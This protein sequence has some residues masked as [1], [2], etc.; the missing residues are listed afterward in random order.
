MSSGPLVICIFDWLEIGNVIKEQG[1]NKYNTAKYIPG[2]AIVIFSCFVIGGLD[3]LGYWPIINIFN[4]GYAVTVTL[5]LGITFFVTSQRIVKELKEM[6]TAIFDQLLLRL[7][8]FRWT[9]LSMGVVLVIFSIIQL[10]TLSFK[11]YD[12]EIFGLT[13]IEGS[14]L[15][16]SYLVTIFYI[17]R[18]IQSP[19]AEE[20]PLLWLID[21]K[22]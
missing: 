2:I 11:R 7:Q 6:P 10:V 18:Q 19:I 22:K 14:I 16:M 4:Y 13:A 8:V 21:G 12:F 1:D 15:A 3:S 5:V 20:S 9:I 17:K